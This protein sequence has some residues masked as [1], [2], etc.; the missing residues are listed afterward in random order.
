MKLRMRLIY[1][2]ISIV[3]ASLILS[4]FNITADCETEDKKKEVSIQPS[5]YRFINESGYNFDAVSPLEN[6]ND[7]IRMGSLSVSGDFEQEDDR[8]GV[9][10]FLVNDNSIISID[11]KYK[12]YV[13][14][15]EEPDRYIANDTEKTINGIE[16]YNEIG[17]GL[18]LLQTSFDGQKW[19]LSGTMNNVS[20]DITFKDGS[21]V[22][23][24]Q[25]INGCYYRIITAYRT[26]KIGPKKY[27]FSSNQLFDIDKHIDAITRVD[28]FISYSEVYEFYAGYKPTKVDEDANKYYYTTKSCMN[29]V[30]NNC[31]QETTE[32]TKSDPHYGWEMGSFCISGYTD[33]GDTDDVYLKSVGDKITLSYK[34]DQDIDMLNGK[35]ELRINKDEKGSDGEFQTL[36][37]DMGRG[38]LIVKYTDEK[39]KYTITEYTDYLSALGAPGANTIVDLFEEGD[40][41]VHLDYSI[42]KLIQPT[43]TANVLPENIKFVSYYKTSFSFKIRNANCMLYTFDCETGSEL[44]NGDVTMNGFKIDSAK[45]SYPKITVKKEILNDTASGLVEDTRFNRTAKDGE[46]FKEE[47]IYTLTAYNRYDDKLEPA[48]KTIYIG[49]NNLLTAYTK[50][51]TMP[52]KYTIEELNN[53]VSNGYVINDS[54]ELVEPQ[55]T[56][57]EETVQ[58]EPENETKNNHIIPITCS[59]VV[60]AAG[61][62]KIFRRKVFRI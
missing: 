57:I 2:C 40:Y 62:A 26:E 44:N 35:T 51:L 20:G 36:P 8:E 16:L 28:E 56:A 58:Q 43:V 25:L 4:M 52:D 14:D 6:Y 12:G 23:D 48:V 32:L 47:G 38:E 33:K 9:P 49:N 59:G 53:Y 34:L 5:V 29:K 15:D 39:G 55:E 31:Y 61:A 21:G 24:L 10:S 17:Y 11:Y 3:A 54:G 13:P 27:D 50:H 22:N 42:A 30:K 45:S 41:E 46:I 60:L 18:V 19:I 1:S 37:H 7:N